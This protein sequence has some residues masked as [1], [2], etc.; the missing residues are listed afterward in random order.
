MSAWCS[1][2]NCRENNNLRDTNEGGREK[3][4]SSRRWEKLRFNIATCTSTYSYHACGD[5][6][7]AHVRTYVHACVVVYTYV[8]LAMCVRTYYVVLKNHDSTG[9]SQSVSEAGIL[10]NAYVQ[11]YVDGVKQWH[12]CAWGEGSSSIKV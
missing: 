11:T 6:F 3:G 10:M 1:C 12:R 8:S 7:A 5:D 2:Q 9:V 4:G